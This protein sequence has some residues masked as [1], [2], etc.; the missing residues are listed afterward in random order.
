MNSGLLELRQF[1][2]SSISRFLPMMFCSI[3]FLLWFRCKDRTKYWKINKKSPKSA[4]S[5]AK[6][7]KKNDFWHHY[8]YVFGVFSSPCI[9]K[10][11][12]DVHDGGGDEEIEW[13]V[14]LVKDD[15]KPW[16]D[17]NGILTIGLMDFLMEPRALE[18]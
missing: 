5:G 4:D 8:R 11:T 2:I 9:F 13:Y 3:S 10:S 15:I 18:L 14:C 16:R 12:D 17:E 7:K 6:S 1:S